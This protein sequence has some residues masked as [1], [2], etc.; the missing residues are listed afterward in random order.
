MMM[1]PDRATTKKEAARRTALMAQ[2]NI[3]YEKG[4]LKTIE[5]LML[6]FGHDPEAIEGEDVASRIV[7][8]IRRV[9]QLRCRMGEIQQE[10]ETQRQSEMYQLKITTEKAEA[11]GGNPLGDLAKQLLEQLSEQKRRLDI[12]EHG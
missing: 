11:L 3:A 8:A 9:A 2:V 12:T 10:L 4:D 6:E 5:K 7:K 1:H